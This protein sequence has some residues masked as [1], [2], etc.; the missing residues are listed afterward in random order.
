M[1]K[2]MNSSVKL[3]RMIISVAATKKRTGGWLD[4]KRGKWQ[5]KGAHEQKAK[6]LAKEKAGVLTYGLLPIGRL[7]RRGRFENSQTL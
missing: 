4:A 1:E 3:Q 5:T 7:N 2:R 6:R